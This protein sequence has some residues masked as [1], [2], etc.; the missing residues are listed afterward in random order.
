LPQFAVP[1]FNFVFPVTTSALGY[2]FREK[3]SVPRAGQSAFS[4]FRYMGLQ[5]S[6]GY[7]IAGFYWV[8][9]GLVGFSVITL[10]EVVNDTYFHT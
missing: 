10:G 4:H 6:V 8:R 1:K 5:Q 2:L 3:G 9:Y 7:R